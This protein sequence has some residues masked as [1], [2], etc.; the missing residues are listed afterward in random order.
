MLKSK[1]GLL[2]SFPQPQASASVL[3]PKS[4]FREAIQLKKKKELAQG[5]G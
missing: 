1:S 5:K 4:Q 3:G 2:W